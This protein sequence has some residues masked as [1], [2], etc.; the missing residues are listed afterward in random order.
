MTFF[1]GVRITM[2]ILTILAIFAVFVGMANASQF[3][4]DSVSI[5]NYYTGTATAGT[6]LTVP[7][8]NTY[9]LLH[10]CVM[11]DNRKVFTADN[12]NTQDACA[13]ANINYYN[14]STFYITASSN[15]SDQFCWDGV[16]KLVAGNTINWGK[17]A[18]NTYVMSNYT[19]VPYDLSVTASDLEVTIAELQAS[20]EAD[21]LYL[22][23]DIKILMAGVYIFFLLLFIYFLG[24]VFFYWTS[25]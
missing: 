8:N 18:M 16:V 5:S 23:N 6:L 24:K 1:T 2:W 21:N 10:A 13:N 12:C 15:L 25:F 4:P 3:P 17:S 20:N 11:S 14:G 22:H 7:A 19:Y 9:T